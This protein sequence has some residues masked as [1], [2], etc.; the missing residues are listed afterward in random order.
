MGELASL[1]SAG[2]LLGKV[3][4]LPNVFPVAVE[5]L[6]AISKNSKV[7]AYTLTN[8]HSD[9]RKGTALPSAATVV[10]EMHTEGR[11]LRCGFM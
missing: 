6:V 8:S 3:G 11:A 1:G 5:T 10:C 9:V 4:A 2:S 7:A